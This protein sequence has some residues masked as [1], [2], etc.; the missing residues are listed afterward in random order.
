[1]EFVKGLKC[2]FCGV[3]YSTRVPYTC[4]AC[5]IAGILDVQYDYPA[6]ATRMT[7]GSLAKRPDYTHWRY[8][9]LLPIRKDAVLP[10]LP[11]GWTRLFELNCSRVTSD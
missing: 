6:I 7:R 1:M 8:R 10:R 5:G 11:V 4:P 2:V 3:V 9:E